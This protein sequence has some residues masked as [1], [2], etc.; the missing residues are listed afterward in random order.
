MA[1]LIY[2]SSVSGNTRRF[3]DKLGR[4]ARRIPLMTADE[5][6]LADE[7][8]V[9]VVPTYGDGHGNNAV[10]K[11]VV[12]FLNVPHNRDLLRG[13]I[14]AGNTNFGTTYGLAADVIAAKCRV[15]TLYRFELFGTPED[16]EA[17]NSGLDSFWQHTPLSTP[18]P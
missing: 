12:K 2:F 3:I 16:V 13:V 14:G 8:Y 11:Q 7:P 10:P 1:Q 18:R 6:I 4:E 5:T 9:L 17:V 15:P